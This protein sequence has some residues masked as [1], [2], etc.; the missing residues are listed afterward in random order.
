MNKIVTSNQKAAERHNK[1]DKINDRKMEAQLTFRFINDFSDSHLGTWNRN[2]VQEATLMLMSYRSPS[3]WTDSK[4][5]CNLFTP[6][7]IQPDANNVNSLW[8]QRVLVSHT[9]DLEGIPTAYIKSMQYC[10]RS[11]FYDK[12]DIF[13]CILTFTSG[14]VSSWGTSAFP[15]EGRPL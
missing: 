13:R 11:Q 9:L 10:L 14:R 5:L 15:A 1:W 3:R 12:A 4:F 8:G 7:T 2:F 6:E